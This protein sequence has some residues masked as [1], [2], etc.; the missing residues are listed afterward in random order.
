M[1]DPIRGLYEVIMT[2]ALE[3]ALGATGE[4][5]VVEAAELRAAEAADRISMHLGRVARRAVMSVPD[6]E[7][8]AK[9]VDLARALIAQIDAAIDDADVSSEKPIAPGRV[10]RALLGKKPDGTP[11]RIA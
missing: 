3:V 5:A 6:N 1:S 10:L 4:H 2:E 7:R 11:E 8:V 9:G